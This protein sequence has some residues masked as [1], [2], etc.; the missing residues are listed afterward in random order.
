MNSAGNIDK[1]II[2]NPPTA[3]P[4]YL[5]GS[6]VSH[7]AQNA[8]V[9]SVGSLALKSLSDSIAPEGGISPF[10][11]CGKTLPRL[12]DVLKPDLVEHGGNL[13]KVTLEGRSV[14]TVS[15][16]RDGVKRDNFVGTSFS[17]P[18]IGGRFAEILKAYGSKIVNSELLKA[19]LFVACPGDPKK[20]QG[21]GYP[22]RFLSADIQRT[23]VATG[24]TIPLSDLTKPRVKE[25][26][27]AEISFRIPSGVK[28]IEL[29]LVHSD[30][31]PSTIAPALDTFLKV[32]ARKDGS[33]SIVK[34]IDEAA[35]E[36]R[37]YAKFLKWK[38]KSRIYER[39]LDFPCNSGNY[40]QNRFKH[41]KIS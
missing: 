10:S 16:G 41:A 24:G 15:F 13:A 21:V 40:S 6:P 9:I 28:E 26:Q 12:Y 11:R 23:V 22:K 35:Q 14:G 8:H 39:T 37:T 18:L 3:Y 5:S 36:K 30:N 31:F 27:V 38:F 25:I 34:T 4:S 29:C 20:C 32:E 19:L 7:P 17:A 1:G 33:D 2:K